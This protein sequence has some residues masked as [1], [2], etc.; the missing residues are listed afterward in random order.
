MLTT[1]MGQFEID[2][3]GTGT[4]NNLRYTDV[5]KLI[6]EKEEDQQQ[7]LG[8]LEAEQNWFELYTPIEWICFWVR[9]LF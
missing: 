7:F 1:N 8:T 6:V 3:R 9:L 5:T 2:R 4:K